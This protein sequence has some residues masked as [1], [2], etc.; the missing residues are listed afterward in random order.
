[1]ST[2]TQTGTIRSVTTQYI[3]GAFVESHGRQIIDVIRP[4]DGQV[5]ARVTLADEEDTRR[6]IAAAKR[7]FATYG[8]STTE[9]RAQSLRRLHKAASA[10][11]GELTAAMI[12]EYG[13][14]AQFARL[15]VESG[16]NAFLAAEHALEELPW[17]RRWDKTTVTLEPVGVAGLITA[18]NANAL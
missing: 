3:D 16:V 11:V 1:M 10:H 6:A 18:W 17:T 8:R 4:T 2:I 12:E 7:A 9:E 14:V 13:G 5:I 15:I